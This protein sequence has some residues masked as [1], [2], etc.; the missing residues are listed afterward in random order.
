M[1]TRTSPPTLIV[2]LTAAVLLPA[3]VNVATGALP[4]DWHPWLWLAWPLAA[5]LAVPVVIAEWRRSRRPA[6]DTAEAPPENGAA[7]TSWNMPQP[8]PTFRERES[9]LDDIAQFVAKNDGPIVLTGMA[10]VGKT[11]IA[12]R[13]AA[14]HRPEF[15]IGWWV[16]A[17][18][19]VAMIASLAQL[20][21][22]LRVG[23]EDQEEAARKALRSLE[24]R[25]RWLLVFDN[26]TEERDLTGLVPAGAGQ[27]LMTS[28]DPNQQRLGT[29]LEV[30]TFDDATAVR[31]LVDRTGSTDRE[32]AAELAAELGGLPLALEQAAAYC[33]SS[34]VTLADYLPRYRE[35]HDHLLRM[36]LPDDRL[37]AG[38]TL[39]LAIRQAAHRDR[40]AIQLLRLCSFLASSTGIPRWLYDSH[41]ELL[42]SPLGATAAKRLDLDRAI[43]VLVTLSLVQREG[44]MLRIHPVVQDVTRDQLSEDDRGGTLHRALQGWRPLS[45][46]HGRE[47]WILLAAEVIGAALPADPADAAGWDRWVVALPHALRVLRHADGIVAAPT[48]ALRQRIGAYLLHRAEFTLATDMLEAAIIELTEVRGADH[49]DTLT[50]RNDRARVLVEV[51][52]LADGAAAHEEVSAARLRALGPEHRDTLIS[53]NN[54][55]FAW[56]RLGRLD[57][58]RALHERTLEVRRRV[59]GPQHPDTLISMGNL[60]LVLAEQGRFAR[61]RELHEHSLEMRR[62]VLGDK[63]PAV[64]ESANNLAIVVSDMGDLDRA[65]HIHEQTLLV[66][67]DLLG[68]HHPDTLMS[69]NNLA[70]VLA[71]QGDL[72]AARELHEQTLAAR[73]RVSGPEH[74]HTLITMNNLALVLA[75][76]GQW[77]EA[78]S[79]HRET[80]AVRQRILGPEHPYCLHSQ[81]NL[82][83]VLAAR[84]HLADAAGLAEQ[85]LTVRRRLLGPDH[86]HTLNSMTNLALIR[87]AQG[88]LGEARELVTRTLEVRRRLLGADHPDTRRSRQNLDR[89]AA[90]GVT[91]ELIAEPT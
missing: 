88:Q 77:A 76:Q 71:L 55:A 79:L 36:G 62:A 83:I 15:E 8:L 54:V 52:R 74:P 90:A 75:A 33:T 3:A 6:I 32:A 78:E 63:H 57:D 17:D 16:P 48:A 69:V 84:G 46:S 11:Q 58:A 14:R 19:R 24:A 38:A 28:R 29:V 81:N 39:A 13:Y 21:D 30:P 59:V 89:L 86:P 9:I 1:R 44:W 47:R 5:V 41:P 34:V 2:I 68:E 26:V 87:A 56:A 22:R 66:R 7:D 45:G 10:G 50:A 49:P 72:D 20:A 61:A 51:G 27:V 91:A 31:F 67:R 35:D 40:A 64:L 43:T 18:T 73:R 12:A 85:T 65:R 42:P 37:T 53:M 4:D 25:G 23:D 60:A 80:L 82:A 70:F